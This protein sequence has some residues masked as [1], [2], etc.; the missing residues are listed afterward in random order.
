MGTMVLVPTVFEVPMVLVCIH[1]NVPTRIDK[2]THT[3]TLVHTHSYTHTQGALSREPFPPCILHFVS[4][5]VPLPL[6]L[7]SQRSADCRA[8][9]SHRPQKEK[10]SFQP[11]ISFCLRH[12][13]YIPYAV[14][15]SRHH[16]T[17][18][19]QTR[20]NRLTTEYSLVHLFTFVFF[21]R[22]ISYSLDR[23]RLV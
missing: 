3:H 4:S 6:S 5:L 21:C 16:S 18:R 11:H 2:R 22:L 23:Y 13:G 12:R 9:R 14:S 15:A 7:V 1:V 20:Q 10:R 8:V 17:S 19:R